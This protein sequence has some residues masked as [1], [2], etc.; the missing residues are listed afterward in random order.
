MLIQDFLD[1]KMSKDIVNS[2]QIFDGSNYQ[3]WK[4]MMKAF[5]Q[6][7]NVWNFVE[8]DPMPEMEDL[9]T[10]MPQP[11]LQTLCARQSGESDDDWEKVTDAYKQYEKDF[12]T[13]IQN[14]NLLYGY[15][16]NE[17]KDKENKYNNDYSF[18]SLVLFW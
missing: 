14:W 16:R 2:V 4:P 11:I 15:L 13:E 18:I 10:I 9:N 3:Q 12:L 6:T 7:Q 5:L 8:N 1:L 17:N